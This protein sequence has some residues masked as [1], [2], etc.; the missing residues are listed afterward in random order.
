M[1]QKISLG[2]LAVLLLIMLFILALMHS[3]YPP[4]ENSAAGGL[5]QGMF[6]FMLVMC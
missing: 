1:D 2:L 6:T 5:V 4:L 3:P